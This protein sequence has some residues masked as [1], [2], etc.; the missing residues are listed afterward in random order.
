VGKDNQNTNLFI[1]ESLKFP[2]G[3]K[4]R[5]EKIFNVYTSVTDFNGKNYLTY[6]LTDDYNNVVLEFFGQH[7]TQANERLLRF[8]ND[9]FF[10]G[11]DGVSI[12]LSRF[13]KFSK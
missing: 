7:M 2:D 4:A 3:P 1:E 10:P 6:R 8:Y 13:Y 9:V 11:K 5:L 12:D